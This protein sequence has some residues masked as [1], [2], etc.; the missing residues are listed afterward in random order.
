MY[1]ITTPELLWVEPYSSGK[2]IV[3]YEKGSLYII[4][5]FIILITAPIF[6]MQMIFSLF[7]M[8]VCINRWC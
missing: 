8:R 7:E 4:V 1:L 3:R 6:M 2:K 5:N